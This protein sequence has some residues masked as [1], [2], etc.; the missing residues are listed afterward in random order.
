MADPSYQMF[1]GQRFK[2]QGWYSQKVIDTEICLWQKICL[3]LLAKTTFKPVVKDSSKGASHAQGLSLNCPSETPAIICDF[4]VF[5]DNSLSDMIWNT[6]LS[7]FYLVSNVKWEVS[8]VFTGSGD[9]R[10]LSRRDH[11]KWRGCHVI[12]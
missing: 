1:E 5:E 11:N 9:T 8:P 7:H 6:F 10:L 2:V 4:T 12:I 3:W